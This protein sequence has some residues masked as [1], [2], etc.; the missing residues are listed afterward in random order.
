[1]KTITQGCTHSKVNK[2]WDKVEKL[3]KELK[4]AKAEFEYMYN[5]N[6]RRTRQRVVARLQMRKGKKSKR[7]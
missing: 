3:K 2:A 1:M 6:V 4:K 5:R 7:K